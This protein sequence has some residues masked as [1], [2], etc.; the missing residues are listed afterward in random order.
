MAYSDFT[1]ELNHINRLLGI[2]IDIE[3]VR[4]CAEKMG[5]VMKSVS[6][7]EMVMEVPPTRS[8]VLHSCDVVEDIGIGY[9]FNNIERVYPQTN[10]VGSYQPNNK[11]SDL[12]R[13]ELAQAGYIEQLTFSLLSIK[14]NYERMRQ[15]VDLA[16]C[17]QLS[18][19]KTIEFEV[20]R[21]SLIPGLLKCLQSNKGQAI[22]Q[23]IFELSDCVILDSSTETGARNVRKIA[24]M[25]LDHSSN[26]EV[27][28]GLLDLLMTKV[29]SK[30]GADYKLVEDC[31]DPRFLTGRG[32]S[33][34]LNDKRIGSMGVLHPEVLG[35]F[36]L[37]YPVSAIEINFDPM[38]DHFKSR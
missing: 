26:F 2:K 27:I 9:G 38:F 37:K 17:V 36:E 4:R 6:G 31:E 21:T 15:N 20:V 5:L 8:D 24:A 11:F 12:T 3:Q 25:V 23:K 10:T 19:P 16:E 22:P 28:H 29:S 18:N 1:V 14:D 30:M 34:M 35:N 32:V 13:Q 33:I 7:T